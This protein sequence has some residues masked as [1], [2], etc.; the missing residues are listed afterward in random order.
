MSA[1]ID[2]FLDRAGWSAARRAPLAGDASHRRY[3]RLTG[4]NGEPAV[5]MIAPPEK[6]ED[7]RPFLSIARLL[8]DAGLT[9]P[10]ILAEDDAAGLIL[11]EDLGDDLFA[12]VCERRPDIE[13]DLYAAAVDVLVHLHGTPAPDLEPYDRPVLIDRAGL[14][15]E[16]YA[17]DGPRGY[18]DPLDA[19]LAALDGL[20]DVVVLRDYH[21][22]NLL[23]LP[24]RDGVERVG[25]L[26]FQD[27]MRGHRAYDLVSLLEDARRDV[28]PDLSERMVRRYVE[29]AGIDD[30]PFRRAFATLGAQRNLRI[31]G[32]FARLCRRDGKPHYLRLIP[33][34]WRHLMSDLAHPDL[35]DLRSAIERDLPIPDDAHIARLA[36]A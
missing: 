16:W 13:E 12:R 28:A 2:G 20:T 4:A 34:V 33:R 25:L 35:A 1:D 36:D 19:A 29:A 3:E 14:A 10:A 6:G 32:V 31:L 24:E 26:D 17:P 23:W 27:A 18:L 8:V 21:A 9:A 15:A 30:A 22:E 5:L 11:M 7:T